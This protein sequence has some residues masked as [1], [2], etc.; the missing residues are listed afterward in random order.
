M[1]AVLGNLTWVGY[2][3]AHNN[4]GNCLILVATAGNNG[5]FSS[6][7][8]SATY[9]GVAMTREQ[10]SFQYVYGADR[11]SVSL[12]RL[13][14]PTLPSGSNNFSVS[15]T[16]GWIAQGY[17]FSVTGVDQTNPVVASGGSNGAYEATLSSLAGGVLIGGLGTRTQTTTMAYSTTKQWE[18]TWDANAHSSV[19]FYKYASSSSTSLGVS[20]IASCGAFISL[21]SAPSGNQAIWFMFKHWQKFLDD[22][23]QGLIPPDLLQKRYKE[24]LVTI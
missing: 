19:F 24:A 2:T 9:G 3:G 21:R 6:S 13:S 4:N 16:Y 20:A 23:R 10:G 18:G 5:A 7:V 12:F 22:L 15:T 1:A 8:D 11:E 17:A 14:G